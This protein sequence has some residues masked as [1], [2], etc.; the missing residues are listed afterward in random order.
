MN[1]AMSSADAAAAPTGANGTYSKSC[2]SNRIERHRWHAV[3][4]VGQVEC[5]DVP[6]ERL[7]GIVVD[8][9]QQPVLR[10]EPV[11]D[12]LDT[13]NSGA[14]GDQLRAA[15]N[16]KHTVFESADISTGLYGQHHTG[17]LNCRY[18][19]LVRHLGGRRTADVAS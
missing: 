16:E 18:V 4:P 19:G 12:G 8:L 11:G 6:R 1:R 15:S 3:V 2:S 13:G 10:V 7:R 5:R 14:V 9:P 17:I